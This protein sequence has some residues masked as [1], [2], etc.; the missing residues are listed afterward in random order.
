MTRQTTLE[1]VSSD[2]VTHK[3]QP[4]IQR[5]LRVINEEA[6]EYTAVIVAGDY[7]EYRKEII[8]LFMCRLFVIYRREQED[9]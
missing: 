1:T 7:V 8:T 6:S 5:E 3:L 9:V 4:Y 2:K